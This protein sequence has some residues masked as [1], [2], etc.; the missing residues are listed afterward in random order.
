MVFQLV[1]EAKGKWFIPLK[2]VTKARSVPRSNSDSF[3]EEHL[4]TG[5]SL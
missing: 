1:S 3:R 4:E 2:M 5:L